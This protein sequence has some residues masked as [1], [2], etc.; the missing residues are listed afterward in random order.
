VLFRL[1][2]TR[3]CV[4]VREVLGEYSGILITDF[5]GGYDGV[6]CRQQ[7]CLVHLIR[8]LNN[9]LWR[10]PFDTELETFVLDVRNL[11]VP[12]ME[13]ANTYGLR[14]RNL[15]KFRKSVD[16]IYRRV[17]TSRTYRSEPVRVY[18]KRFQRYRHSLFTFL[19]YDRIPWNNNMGERALRH[20]TVQRKISG[21]FHESL[22]PAYLLLLGVAQTRRFQDKSLL[23]FLLSGEK[24][25]DTFK[26]TKQRRRATARRPRAE[27][28]RSGPLAHS[29]PLRCRRRPQKQGQSRR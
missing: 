9:D 5:Y 15:G 18:Q 19:E 28:N 23:K 16:S 17:I 21:S 2:A 4:V 11:L 1:T 6:P 14:K 12:I 20:L 13:A 22:A 26:P 10:R 27:K 8:D 25:V 7:K 24:D 29:E 3:E